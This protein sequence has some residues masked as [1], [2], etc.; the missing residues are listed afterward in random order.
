MATITDRRGYHIL[1]WTDPQT[2][3]RR[4][5]SLG[6]VG[7]IPKRD[8]DDLLRIKEYELST[9]AR[10]LN[11]H[12]RPAPRFEEY[13]RTYLIWHRA[14]YPDSHYRVEQIAFDHLIPHFGGTPLNLLSI[15]QAEDYK[16]VRRPLVTANTLAKEW[17]VFMAFLNRAVE[18][19]V[20]TENPLS[21]VKAP[22]S[23]NSKPHHYYQPHE[24]KT[25]YAISSYGPIW[26]FMANTGLRRGEALHM[27]RAWITDAV[28]IQSTG[29]ERTKAGEWRKIP[30]TDGA[31]KALALIKGEPHLIPRMAPESLSRAFK[32]DARKAKVGGSLHSLRHTYICHLLLAGVP[33]RT[34]QLYAG[35]ANIS[36]TEKYAYQVLAQDPKQALRLAI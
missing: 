19:K 31:R 6:K 13:A 29:E 34:V 18:T 3:R 7:T 26:R 33:I 28:R 32:R 23:L 17:R 4:N 24:L 12:R 30:L 5:K 15:E 2:G 9:G 36:T 14:E 20:I 21:A 25:I 35:H 11:V 16:A 8:L 22:Q 1:N 27:R 10:L